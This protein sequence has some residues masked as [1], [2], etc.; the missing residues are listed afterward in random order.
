MPLI[1]LTNTEQQA[2]VDDEDFEH[3]DQHT[4]YLHRSGS[5]ITRTEGGAN[6]RTMQSM[7]LDAPPRTWVGFR[8]SD[9]L[10]CRKANLYL[11]NQGVEVQRR[12]PVKGQYK[13]V[14]HL[15]NGKWKARIMVDGKSITIGSSYRTEHD[16]ALAYDRAAVKYFG[17]DAYLNFPS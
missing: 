16:A 15:K 14:T 9:R 13:G 11:R 12:P 7:V 17:Q 6:T 1:D 3:I 5:V 4:W 8:D 10:N 2:V